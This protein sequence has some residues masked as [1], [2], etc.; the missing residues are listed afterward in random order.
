MTTE[1]KIMGDVL[2]VEDDE[3]IREILADFCKRMD[4]FGNIVVVNDGLMASEKMKNQKFCL[5]LVDLI[6]PK[7]AG[8][9]LIR[10][11]DEK[12]GN[13]KKNIIIVS[14]ALNETLIA[15]IEVLGVMNFLPK[16]FDEESFKEKALKVLA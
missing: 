5:M 14:G 8:L 15:K 6:L 11:L 16:P 3:S 9:D 2:I 13:L 7:K 12:S 1:K 10:E 4:C